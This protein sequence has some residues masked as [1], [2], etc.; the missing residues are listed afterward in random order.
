[1]N[2]L[3]IGAGIIIQDNCCR[4]DPLGCQCTEYKIILCDH[5]PVQCVGFSV[6]GILD[7]RV[8]TVGTRTEQSC[9]RNII[10]SLLDPK[11]IQFV[12]SELVGIH[13]KSLFRCRHLI[14]RAIFSDRFR[15]G[16]IPWSCHCQILSILLH[17]YNKFLVKLTGGIIVI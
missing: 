5:L 7:R 3:W 6:I 12:S 1:M 15:I 10:G 2:E 16:D 4:R 9:Y 13:K 17:R 8:G 14:N 11:I